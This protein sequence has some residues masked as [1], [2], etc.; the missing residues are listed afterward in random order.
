MA[1]VVGQPITLYCPLS[2]E[3]L[4]V[5]CT[6]E[7][8]TGSANA[9]FVGE[10]LVATAGTGKFVAESTSSADAQFICLEHIDEVPDVDTLIWAM[11]QR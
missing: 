9:F 3:M 6:G 11:C 5:L 10:R 8:G 2:G 7:A 1:A 4:N